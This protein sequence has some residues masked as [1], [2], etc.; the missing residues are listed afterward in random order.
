MNIRLNE[1]KAPYK[2]VRDEKLGVVEKK[3]MEKV[4]AELEERKKNGVKINANTPNALHF[5]HEKEF[6]AEIDQIK[7]EYEEQLAPHQEEM[8]AIDSKFREA[9]LMQ[10]AF[11]SLHYTGQYKTG[12][13]VERRLTED[14]YQEEKREKRFSDYANIDA[15]YK[16]YEPEKYDYIKYRTEK[17]DSVQLA[18]FAK[19]VAEKKKK[20]EESRL[21]SKDFM[22]L[23]FY[24]EY[25]AEKVLHQDMG[26]PDGIRESLNMYTHLTEA[27]LK[28]SV[29]E[30][31]DQYHLTELLNS[32]EDTEEVRQA[33][34]AY[35]KMF[36]T[37]NTYRS[38]DILRKTEKR[39]ENIKLPDIALNE[40]KKKHPK[41]NAGDFE[42]TCKRFMKPVKYIEKDGKK[43]CASKQD[44][45]NLAFNNQWAKSLLSNKEKDW[46]FRFKEMENFIDKTTKELFENIGIS[47][48]LDENYMYE[49]LEELFGYAD[50]ILILSGINEH[51]EQNNFFRSG[52]Y[53]SLPQERQKELSNKA[54]LL[55]FYSGVLKQQMMVCG[56]NVDTKKP[57]AGEYKEKME[58]VMTELVK[59]FK[60]IVSGA[61]LGNK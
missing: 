28:E 22:L 33:K 35:A 9:D 12:D 11:I 15:Y 20:A 25:F 32:T 55:T 43:I 29:K 24:H 61:G 13:T 48:L 52:Y 54:E 60:D 44:E 47:N 7:K 59:I 38:I 57:M 6:K 36:S 34:D 30:F 10:Q 50:R 58:N 31:D 41:Y 23:R 21:Q 2:K 45:E 17:M 53:K 19:L 4:H 18:K 56:A 40:L 51:A 1:I 3:I 26:G 49:H 46:E 8:D 16:V 39:V 5:K 42:R 14:K 27:K 37:E